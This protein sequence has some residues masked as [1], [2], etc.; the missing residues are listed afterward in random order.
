M[1]TS[2]VLQR[3]VRQLRRTAEPPLDGG[4]AAELL[5]RIQAGD[6]EAFETILR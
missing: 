1:L 4:A 5:E 2:A 6:A 3:L